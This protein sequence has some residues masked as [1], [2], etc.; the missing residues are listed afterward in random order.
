MSNELVLCFVLCGLCRRINGTSSEPLPISFIAENRVGSA[1][2][3]P[4]A[5]SESAAFDLQ[6]VYV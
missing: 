1:N 2:D 5:R 3:L 6:S 4:I